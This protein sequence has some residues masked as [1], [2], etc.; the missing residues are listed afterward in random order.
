M[1]RRKD[2]PKRTL[3]QPEQDAI[4]ITGYLDFLL[5]ARWSILAYVAIA[6]LLGAAYAFFSKPVY[7]A[8]LL[9]EV[10]ER[11]NS[12]KGLLSDVS[13][14]FNVKTET[15]TEIEILRSR[16]VVSGAVDRLHLYVSAEPR[17]FPLAGSLI[18]ARSQRL[19]E[20]GLWGRGGFAWGNER[21]DVKT[22]DVPQ[23]FYGERFDLEF[24]GHGTYR[25]TSPDGS[26]SFE[27]GVGRPETF[28]MP[29]GTIALEVSSINARPGIRF[30]LT[31]AS[32]L[33]TIAQLQ[34]RLHF[35]D[36]TKESRVVEVTLEC[37]DRLQC[38][39][40]MHAIGA[41]YVAQNVERKAA[42]A[43]QSLVFLDAQL[44]ALR[45]QLDDSEEKY[46]RF[47]DANGT[48][49]LSAEGQSMLQQ[50]TGLQEKLLQLKIQKGDLSIR[51]SPTHPSIIALDGRIS[52]LEHAVDE[53]DRA[54]ARLPETERKAIG[55]MRNV[56]VDTALYS[57]LMNNGQQLKVIKAG[58]TGTV[59]LVDDAAMPVRPVKPKRLLI[60]GLA[61][62]LGVI[63]GV[64]AASVR[65]AFFGSLPDSRELERR[66]GLNVLG[67]VPQSK[68]E[69][70]LRSGARHKGAATT[71]L[72]HRQP[73]DPAME[74]MR[75]LRSALHYAVQSAPNNIV[76]LA[77][78]TAGVGSSFISANFAEVLAAGGRK[79]LLID[80][81]LH[82]GRL[83]E[84]FQ[85][86]RASGLAELIAGTKTIE[87]VTRPLSG[88]G[89][90]FIPTGALPRH[91]SELISS[92][93]LRSKL[94][95]LAK[96][97]DVVLID[98]PPI[99]AASDAQAL[100]ALSGS[101]FLIARHGVSK[102]AEIREAMK[103]LRLAGVIANGMIVNGIKQSRRGD[104]RSASKDGRF[105]AAFYFKDGRTHVQTN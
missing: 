3:W 85:M 99:L 59:R 62:M 75:G 36:R 41:E 54:I 70:S 29:D 78:L 30:T 52:E 96:N 103:R 22:F 8:G 68:T 20:P 101:V 1:V 86:P 92:G 66:T 5:Q 24:L 51:F 47:R 26:R 64:V 7:Q 33:Q 83:N 23:E 10:E 87:H 16:R 97:Y 71:L 79:V 42:D 98:A 35:S 13:S 50:S 65:K 55:L 19:S 11:S 81:D 53:S 63:L 39:D 49:N 73:H 80:G 15:P 60:I 40:I 25:L 6:T 34:E 100:G 12:A 88:G 31:R 95:L 18:A 91:P 2:R 90:A 89:L 67:T 104:Y 4:A 56:Q 76:T 57:G 48:I 27:G 69:T 77:G 102:L 94:E 14:L 21:I 28:R 9:V 72:A 43:A 38:R 61:L 105:G 84:Y 45:K 37:T 93:A 44:P 17:Y 82:D 58:R 74:S 32:R 46:R